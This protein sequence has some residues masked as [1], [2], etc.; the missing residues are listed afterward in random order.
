MNDQHVR[1]D[2]Y[3]I[4]GVLFASSVSLLLPSRGLLK[5]RIPSWL[6]SGD[7]GVSFLVV[8]L[9]ITTHACDLPVHRCQRFT[10]WSGVWT[11]FSNL[12]LFTIF[13]MGFWVSEHRMS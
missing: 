2:V 4:I 9:G 7:S 3:F 1:T 5:L 6:I 13:Q 10:T 11:P 8:A 12:S